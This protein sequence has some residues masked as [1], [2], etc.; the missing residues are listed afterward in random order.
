[1]SNL[2]DMVFSA[3]KNAEA[4][5]YFIGLVDSE[6][7]FEEV[8]EDLISCDVDFEN[9]S[10]YKILPFVREYFSEN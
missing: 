2:K 4:N 3:L 9:Q 6:E 10:V 7:A 8:A 5:G 1:M